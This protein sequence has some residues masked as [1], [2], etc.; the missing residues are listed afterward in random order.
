MTETPSPSTQPSRPDRVLVTVLRR[1]GWWLLA[2]GTGLALFFGVLSWQR[3]GAMQEQLARQSAEAMSVS[4]EAR[5]LAKQ[6]ITLA[7]DVHSRAAV[8]ESRLGEV[9]V[10]RVRLEELLDNLSRSRE[11]NLLVDLDA[12]LRLAQQQAQ[13]TGSVEP[14]LAALQTAA[15]RTKRAAQPRLAGLERAIAADI[16]QVRSTAFSDTPGLLSLMDELARM[17]DGLMLAN[18]VPPDDTATVTPRPA[19][20]TTGQSWW[21]RGMLA[22]ADELRSLVRIHRVDSADAALLS[23]QQAFF[24][25]ENFKLKILNA[26]LCLLSRQDRAAVADL[27][28]AQALLR[29]YFDAQSRKTRAT[30]ELL[31]RLL[32]RMRYLQLPGIEGTFTALAAV[33]PMR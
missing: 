10:Q 27:Q 30:S 17:V 14:L 28:E 33:T 4:M 8:F 21:K 16:D 20:D 15:R 12:T 32:T 5:V 24:V 11:E 22:V 1:M 19:V 9:S 29:K 13:W 2:L 18:A 7:Q 23:P 3:I 6:A 26:R 31:Q 25:R